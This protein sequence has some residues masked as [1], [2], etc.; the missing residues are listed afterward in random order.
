M[1]NQ[2]QETISFLTWCCSKPVDGPT[3]IDCGQVVDEDG[4]A[5]YVPVYLY[6][7]L[8]G[9]SE[10]WTTNEAYPDEFEVDIRTQTYGQHETMEYVGADE[11]VRLRCE[12][13][14]GALTIDC[15]GN[16]SDLERGDD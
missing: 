7:P 2:P 6:C 15:N 5:I 10:R 8:C 9:E 14:G 16:L 3:C 13:C 11:T 12:C 1:S 4:Q